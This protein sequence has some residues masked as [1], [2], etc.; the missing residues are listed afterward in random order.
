MGPIP[1]GPVPSKAGMPS[2][3]FHAASECGEMPCRPFPV[4][5]IYEL[6]PIT[7]TL[8]FFCQ[9]FFWACAHNCLAGPDAAAGLPLHRGF[10][11]TVEPRRSKIFYMFEPRESLCPVKT[12]RERH[13]RPD[14]VRPAPTDQIVRGFLAPGDFTGGAQRFCV[15]GRRAQREK[16]AGTRSFGRPSAGRASPQ[17]GTRHRGGVRLSLI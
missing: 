12:R 14:G 6:T 10:Y 11:C 13:G 8:E 7:Y 4:R 15:T 9:G 5:T 17:R 1:A 2:T 3:S 16:T